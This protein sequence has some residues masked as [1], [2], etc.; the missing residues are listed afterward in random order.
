M[1][2]CKCNEMGNWVYWENRENWSGYITQYHIWLQQSQSHVFNCGA[3]GHCKRECTQ[4]A[5]QGNRNPFNS[6]YQNRQS[7][8]QVTCQS[9]NNNNYQPQNN[10]QNRQNTSPNNSAR[11]TTTPNQTQN[12]TSHNPTRTI[13]AISTPNSQNQTKNQNQALVIQK[14]EGFDWTGMQLGV[15]E[16]TAGN[17]ACVAQKIDLEEPVLVEEVLEKEKIS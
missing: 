14:D 12:Q 10:Y 5:Q 8:N 7:Q 15:E 13:I 16:I 11:Q 4:P 3:K 2:F 9:Q 1:G 17:V 6:N